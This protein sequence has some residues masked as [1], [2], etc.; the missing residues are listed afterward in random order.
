MAARA[1]RPADAAMI[2]HHAIRL[3]PSSPALLVA[4][5]AVT[6]GLPGR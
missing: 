2:A 1:G 5:K 6:D 4:A 3:D